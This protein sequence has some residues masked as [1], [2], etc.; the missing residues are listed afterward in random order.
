MPTPSS[1]KE[2]PFLMGL[3]GL[4]LVS[5]SLWMLANTRNAVAE[6]RI[7]G[8]P[9]NV[10]DTITIEGEGKVNAKPDIAQ[11]V[12]G[13]TSEGVDLG[14]VQTQ[15]TQ[16]MNALTASLKT[17]G[18]AEKDL[19]TQQYS[20]SPKYDYSNNSQ[21]ITGYQVSQQ[22]VVKIR[23]LSKVGSLITQAAQLGA[24]QVN[25]LTFTFDDPSALQQEARRKA[26]ED[27]REK[28][29][30]LAKALGVNV[31]RV[32]SFSES[33]GNGSTSMPM[34]AYAREA[35]AMK[36]QAPAPDIQVGSS[37]LASHLSVTFEIR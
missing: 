1:I 30:D 8:K 17:A 29:N 3:A 18:V 14:Q 36:V 15:N 4:A 23:D 28:A 34:Y 13:V 9:N 26:I 27:A 35:D 24:N 10:R 12:M 6:Y 31:V 11:V 7:I 20:I 19:Q 2:S 33:T 37:D 22:L 5:L 16:K 25:A 21:R 32:V